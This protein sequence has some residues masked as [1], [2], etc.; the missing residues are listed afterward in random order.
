Y[1]GRGY[2]QN[3]SGEMVSGDTIERR[4]VMV[5]DDFLLSDEERDPKQWLRQ[6]IDLMTLLIMLRAPVLTRITG[7][8]GLRQA[9]A[10]V[11]V[12]AVGLEELISLMSQNVTQFVR[13]AEVIYRRLADEERIRLV[14]NAQ[15]NIIELFSHTKLQASAR[16]D[17]DQRTM[18]R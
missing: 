5:V 10:L 6:S 8:A 12:G 13:E 4:L 2:Y 1:R 3:A 18:V 14:K 17:K 16:K 7:D 9:L 15:A 11:P